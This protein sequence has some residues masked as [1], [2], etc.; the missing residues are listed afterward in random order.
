M[1]KELKRVARYLLFKSAFGILFLKIIR[2]F[3]GV[4]RRWN[5]PKG[6]YIDPSAQILGWSNLQIG[7]NSVVSERCWLNVNHRGKDVK[8]LIVGDHCFMGRDNQVSVAG[9]ISF[10]D[11]LLTAPGCRFLSATH[12][13]DDPTSPYIS[14]GVTLDDRIRIGANCFFGSASMVVGNVVIGHGSVVGAG[15]VV[16]QDIPPFSLVI[17]NP[18][19]VVKRYCFLRSQWIRSADIGSDPVFPDEAS[20]LKMLQAKNIIPDMPIIAASRRGGEL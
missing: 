14:T 6:T 11:Y 4:V 18:G 2:N 16:C 1:V 20:Y 9:E 7:Q 15:A 8:S 5:L 3:R 19:R 12:L 10:G 13:Y 17:G